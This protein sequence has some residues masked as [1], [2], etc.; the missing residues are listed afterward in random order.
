MKTSNNILE[1]L[2]TYC[3]IW[4]RMF[5]KLIKRKD[6]HHNSMKITSLTDVSIHQ[7]NFGIR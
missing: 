5:S 6:I 3:F 7:F 1:N 2:E 4:F